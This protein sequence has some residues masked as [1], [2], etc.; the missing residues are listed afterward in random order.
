MVSQLDLNPYLISTYP[1]K[2][3]APSRVKININNVI[4]T[5]KLKEIYK[6]KEN[7]LNN[8]IALI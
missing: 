2:I 4:K 7:W 5:T 1:P 6:L 3:L 8:F